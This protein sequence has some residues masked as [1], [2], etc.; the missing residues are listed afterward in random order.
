MYGQK[1]GKWMDEMWA[2]FPTL[3]QLWWSTIKAIMKGIIHSKS[4][5]HKF[6]CPY[7]G[8]II[9]SSRTYD[10]VSFFNTKL[11]LFIE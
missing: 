11:P 2:M 3:L 8:T 7:I 6:P 9:L 4:V 10:L 1:C 5:V